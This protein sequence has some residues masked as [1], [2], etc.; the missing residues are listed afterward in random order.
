MKKRQQQKQKTPL[1]QS[2]N[3]LTVSSITVV[4]LVQMSFEEKPEKLSPSLRRDKSSQKPSKV[5]NPQEEQGHQEK[6]RIVL[7]PRVLEW[8]YCLSLA[9]VP[10]MVFA[11]SDRKRES[12]KSEVGR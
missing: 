5:K 10:M 4:V 2:L 12:R 9:R 8:H 6:D 11:K 3:L 1:L 7:T